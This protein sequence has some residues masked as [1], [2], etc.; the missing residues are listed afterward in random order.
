MMSNPSESTERLIE[1]LYAKKGLW[2]KFVQPDRKQP[3]PKRGR[4]RAT[5]QFSSMH[6]PIPPKGRVGS[7]GRKLNTR[8]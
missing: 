4:K 7:Q 6:S 8:L 5:K 3:A 2:N 1:A